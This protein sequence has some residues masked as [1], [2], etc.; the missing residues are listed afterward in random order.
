MRSLLAPLLGAALCLGFARAQAADLPLLLGKKGKVL[1][2]ESFDGEQPPK[3]FAVNTG[4]LGGGGGVLHASQIA[5]D[6][7][8]GAFRYRLPVQDCAIQVDFRFE[9]ARMFNLGFDPTPGELKKKGHLFS[10]IV[11]P[12]TWNIT[13]H[14]DKADPNSKNKVHAAGQLKLEKGKWYTLLLETKGDHVAAQINGADALRATSQDFHVKKPGLVFRMGGKDGDEVHFD[15]L[16][17][18]ELK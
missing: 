18:W 10:V 3:G 9:G 1:L 4:K 17:V 16:K 11:T 2:E 15:N 14:I 12:A 5:K 7:H 6:D 8:A 13:E